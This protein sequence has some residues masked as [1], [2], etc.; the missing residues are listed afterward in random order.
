M[1]QNVVELPY[2]Y[3]PDFKR[4]RPVFNGDIYVGEVGTDPEIPA[5][6]KQVFVSEGSVFDE[7]A[8]AVAQ[9]IPT[10]AGGV[11]E[12][13]GNPVAVFVNGDY[14]IKV[15]DR[16]GEQVYYSANARSGEPLTA[17]TG[18]TI[19][20]SVA[21]LEGVD[22]FEGQQINVAKYQPDASANVG[23]GGFVWGSGRHDG[24]LFIDPN[25][26]FP[27]DWDNSSQVDAWFADSGSDVEC[28]V[29]EEKQISIYDFGARPN[30]DSSRSIRRAIT[31][32]KGA[33]VILPTARFIYDGVIITDD[34]VTLHGERAPTVNA[35]F[36]SLE[37]GSIIE[38]TF[39]TSAK[40]VD[41]R[42][43][44]AD[45]GTDTA[46]QDGDGIRCTA[47]INQGIS[48]NA[49]NV[50][51]LLKN[52]ASPF[53]ATLFESY[54]KF[55]GGNITGVQGFFGCVIKCQ[56]VNLTSIYTERNNSD[57]LFL[58]SDTSF[59]Q[60]KHVNIDN[61][62]G[63]G[64]GTQDFGLRVQADNAELSSVNIG[65]VVISGC[66]TSVITQTLTAPMTEVNI[67]K[68]ILIEPSS[69]G[70]YSQAGSATINGFNINELFIIN[71]ENIGV[72][73]SGSQKAVGI[74]YANIVYASGTTQT[75]WD[76]GILVGSVVSGTAFDIVNINQLYS[77][78]NLGSITY[79]NATFSNTNV[80]GQYTAFIK[81][82]GKPTMGFSAPTDTGASVKITPVYNTRE[83][84][85]TIKAK[86][87]ADT[88]VTSIEFVAGNGELYDTGY[89]ITVI[90]DS[91]FIY[92][93][94]NNIAGKIVNKGGLN[95]TIPTNEIARYVFGGGVWHE[96]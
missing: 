17:E 91:T 55:T 25:R 74:G 29:R 60:C 76:K 28:W 63:N 39:N 83:K 72:E 22:G 79:N 5:N 94:N 4:G 92:T 34:V 14:S 90:N 70:V 9:P 85:S 30:E 75:E 47:P 62:I 89:E 87:T 80:L 54:Q 53:H 35:S 44:W 13:N 48:L 51:G 10:S 20:G 15:L 16:F 78:V 36:S 56:N 73:Y 11:P 8:V 37:N 23:G 46:A 1:A 40:I 12:N 96:V 86:P 41:I 64:D 32:S 77:S 2:K 67:D 21:E 24:G 84:S 45:L 6:Q 95:V 42:N 58:K 61:F 27:T 31:S 50:G 57:G 93:I 7:T 65:Q 81:G 3:Y 26:E 49:E 71:A 66:E 52:V 68:A 33:P 18:I 59:G 38:G 88:T 43:F 19:F 69:R 82:S